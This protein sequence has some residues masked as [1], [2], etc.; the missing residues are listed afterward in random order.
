MMTQHWNKTYRG[1]LK[2]LSFL[3]AILPLHVLGSAKILIFWNS[4]PSFMPPRSNTNCADLLHPLCLI[5]TSENFLWAKTVVWDVAW[6]CRLSHGGVRTGRGGP[7][8]RPP[9]FESDLQLVMRP[10]PWDSL[11]YLQDSYN[12]TQFQGLKLY[13]ILWGIQIFQNWSGINWK[14]W[15][16]PPGATTVCH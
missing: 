7:K 13:C 2:F 8:A 1:N 4:S 10:K 5:W 16:N 6:T 14:Q 11:L 12:K 15:Q 9:S 3:G